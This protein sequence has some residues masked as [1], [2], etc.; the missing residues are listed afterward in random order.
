MTD[1]ERAR[2]LLKDGSYT[3]VLCRGEVLHTSTKRG[4]APLVD[5]IDL[6]ADLHGCSAADK[7]VGKA[8]ALLFVLAGVKAVYAPVMSREATQV[9][10]RYGI[11]YE[12]DTTC[13]GIINRLGTGSCPMEQAV[14][15]IE[16]PMKALEAVRR[17]MEQ[18]RSKQEG[19]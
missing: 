9:F 8:A 17:T 5:W 15:D 1:W 11:L 16:E 18:L 14:R 4:V 10:S 13:E 12:C 3:C 2:N 7:I 19:K 6:G